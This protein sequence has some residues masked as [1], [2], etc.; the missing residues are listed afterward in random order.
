M[1]AE[2]EVGAG[3]PA[4]TPTVSLQTHAR[5]LPGETSLNQRSA[6]IKSLE[7]MQGY[8]AFFSHVD[9]RAPDA[10]YDAIL[11]VDICSIILWLCHREGQRVGPMLRE[12]APAIAQPRV[13]F[14]II[15]LHFFTIVESRGS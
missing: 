6:E 5:K 12:S 14:F 2:N 3:P 4:E 8:S 1:A 10:L 7:L 15:P 9:S 13:Y 11:A